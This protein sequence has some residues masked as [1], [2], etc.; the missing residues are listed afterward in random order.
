MVAR[1]GEDDLRLGK[2]RED[3][4]RT[5]VDA[6]KLPV[7]PVSSA[8][9]PITGLTTDREGDGG[10]SER[11]LGAVWG[12]GERPRGCAG[13]FKERGACARGSRGGWSRGRAGLGAWANG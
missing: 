1:R 2:A 7:A 5:P 4:K 10:F 11:A 12:E 9:P 13:M 8:E 6:A 3:F